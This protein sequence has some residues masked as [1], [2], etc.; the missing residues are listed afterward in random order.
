MNRMNKC[1]GWQTF[2][3]KGQAVNIGFAGHL[4]SITTAQTCYCS[5]TAATDNKEMSR[6]VHVVFH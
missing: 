1:G 4:V 6:D 3:V 2:T 5:V